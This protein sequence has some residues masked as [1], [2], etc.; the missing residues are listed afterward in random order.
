MPL[1]HVESHSLDIKKGVRKTGDRTIEHRL[2]MSF[3]R[4]AALAYPF[5]HMRGKKIL[6]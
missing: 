1:K 6:L 4:V 3:N 2:R 5:P